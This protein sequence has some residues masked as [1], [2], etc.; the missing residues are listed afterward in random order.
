MN[1]RPLHDTHGQIAPPSGPTLWTQH[2]YAANDGETIGF[3]D[4]GPGP[5]DNAPA[6]YVVRVRQGAVKCDSQQE[7]EAWLQKHLAHE[8]RG[9]A[10]TTLVRA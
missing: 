5:D 4:C 1:Q 6:T 7:A 10:A 8:R 3:V 2:Y 9:K